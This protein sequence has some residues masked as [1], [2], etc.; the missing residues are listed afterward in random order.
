MVIKFPDR[1]YNGY[2]VGYGAGFS[3]GQ[4]SR[5]R[6]SICMHISKIEEIK[7]GCEYLDEE[8]K[9]TITLDIDNITVFMERKQLMEIYEKITEF[10]KIT[11]NDEIKEE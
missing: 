1:G 4:D 10:L 2:D 7:M 3:D 8:E 9:D 6:T 5:P 11:K